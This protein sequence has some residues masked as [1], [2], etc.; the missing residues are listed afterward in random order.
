MATALSPK[1]AT[2][3]PVSSYGTSGD[4]NWRMAQIRPQGA[5]VA[6]MILTQCAFVGADALVPGAYSQPYATEL[7]PGGTTRSSEATLPLLL[8]RSP[9]GSCPANMV[10]APFCAQS[11]FQEPNVRP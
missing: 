3:M 9:K 8:S 11:A 7:M 1:L 5:P 2:I 10:A 6:D 4:M